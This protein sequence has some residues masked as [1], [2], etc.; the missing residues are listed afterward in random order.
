MRQGACITMSDTPR[1]CLSIVVPVYNEE[2]NVLSLYHAV[3]EIMQ[4]LSKQYEYELIFTD[5]HSTDSTFAKLEQLASLDQRVSVFRF[6]RNFGYQRS[7][8]TGYLKA[9]GDAA[10]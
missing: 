7:I 10:I 9:R 6:S 8:I 1:K 3:T 4:P 5:N 2:D